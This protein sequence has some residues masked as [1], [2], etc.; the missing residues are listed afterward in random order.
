MMVGSRKAMAANHFFFFFVGFY[1][2]SA[3]CVTYCVLVSCVSLA[4]HWRVIVLP[5]C[6]FIVS[7][8]PNNPFA[9]RTG[10]E[11]EHRDVIPASET[12]RLASLW[13]L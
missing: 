3:M 7:G 8:A 13:G 6:L 2:A 4:R 11:H 1:T 5:C 10:M 9:M 12:H